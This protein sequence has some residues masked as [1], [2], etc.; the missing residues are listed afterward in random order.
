[1]SG[2]ESYTDG[3][4]YKFGVNGFSSNPKFVG[5]ADAENPFAI[6]RTSP[7]RNAGQVFDWMSGSTDIRG[8][9]FMRLR[10]G[11]V[12]IGCYQCW[13]MPTGLKISVR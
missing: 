2:L 1:V 12:D 5:N 3:T 7:L 13:L 10:D 9:G 6:K 11:K 4:V 8:E